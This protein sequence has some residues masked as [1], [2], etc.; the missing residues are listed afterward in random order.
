M[1]K[2]MI[3]KHTCAYSNDSKMLLCGPPPMVKAMVGH[4]TDLGWPAPNVISKLPDSV[5]KF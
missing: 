1:S 5:F 2:A 3:E 4:L